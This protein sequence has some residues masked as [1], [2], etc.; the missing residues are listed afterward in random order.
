MTFG[1]ALWVSNYGAPTSVDV[2]YPSIAAI[3]KTGSKANWSQVIA[4]ASVTADCHWMRVSTVKTNVSA[5]DT[6]A[7][8][9]IGIS[10]V[11]SPANGDWTVLIADVFAGH[12]DDLNGNNGAAGV[13]DFFF[14]IK[15]PSGYGVAV[16]GLT[17]RGADQSASIGVELRGNASGSPFVGTTCT[18]HG[19]SGT[20]GTSVTPGS[21]TYGSWTTIGSATAADYQALVPGIQPVA[22]TTVNRQL[23][24]LQLGWSSTQKTG[25]TIVH[26][27]TVEAIAGLFLPEYV[28]VPSGT[29]L[30]ARI[31]A[32]SGN[33][34]DNPR[35]AIYGISA[36]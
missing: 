17:A 29:T 12:I 22:G 16:R 30:Q 5:T 18:T 35:V 3:L 27:S 33:T 8:I 14:P 26:T 9:D 23:Y 25:V 19:V 4:K 34:I 31:A 24:M 36:T 20:G 32:S 2:A 15:V 6:S 10:N 28:F 21:D 7:V 1:D 13:Y 11:S